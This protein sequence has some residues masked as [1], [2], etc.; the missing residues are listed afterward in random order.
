LNKTFREFVDKPI[1][2]GKK[3][4]ITF[5]ENGQ[6]MRLTIRTIAGNKGNYIHKVGLYN[7]TYDDKQERM[8]RNDEII[9]NIAV[10]YKG[11]YL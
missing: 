11:I 7:I 10:V 3:E 5:I 4:K 1:A 9:R 8:R 2:S 6:Y